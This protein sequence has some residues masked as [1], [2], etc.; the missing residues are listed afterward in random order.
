MKPY[1]YNTEKENNQKRQV[2]DYSRKTERNGKR[3]KPAFRK[4]TREGFNHLRQSV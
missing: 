3:H 2:R 4:R 1:L